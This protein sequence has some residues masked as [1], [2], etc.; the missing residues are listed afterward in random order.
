MATVRARRQEPEASP[1]VRSQAPVRASQSLCV[2][3]SVVPVSASCCCI[4]TAPV[5]SRSR[6]GPF[7]SRGARGLG[8]LLGSRKR[9]WSSRAGGPICG[10]GSAAGWLLAEATGAM[11]TGLCVFHSS[12]K[13]AGLLHVCDRIPGGWAARGPGLARAQCPLQRICWPQARTN[14][15]SCTGSRWGNWT[16][17]PMWTAAQ[18]LHRERVETGAWQ[19]A[20]GPQTEGAQITTG[21]AAR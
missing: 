11:V 21:W 18:S 10:L 2:Q 16:P 4:T 19:A 3:S 14:L 20:Q 8:R 7:T 17:P 9:V 6:Q 15:R 1:S 13:L 5:R 12:G